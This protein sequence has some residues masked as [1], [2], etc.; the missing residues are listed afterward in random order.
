MDYRSYSGLAAVNWSTLREMR[1]SPLH[2]QHRLTT[3]RDDTRA[4]A[5]GRASHTA[6]FEPQRFLLDYAIYE[7][8]VRRGK[9]WDACCA[10]NKGKTILSPDQ[11]QTCLD[12][13]AAVRAHPEAG[14]ALT[15]PGEAEK[16]I[17]WTDEITGI[18]CKGRMD[19]YRPGLLADLKTTARAL[20]ADELAAHVYRLGYH[21]Q[22]AFYRAGLAANGLDAPPFTII[23][24]ETAPPHD[25]GVFTL[26]DDFMWR[27]EQLVAELLSAVSRARFA[28]SWPGRYPEIRSLS[29]PRWAPV[30]DDEGDGLLNALGLKATGTED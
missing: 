14:P 25:V 5:F 17:T 28:Q 21:G 27:G 15:P 23:A 22:G 7:G 4:M 8:K 10:A 6:V 3:P 12:V 16:T 1:L 24:V 26:D 9:E 18:A 20:D 19:W 30:T 2:Y 13:A 29:L 11:Y